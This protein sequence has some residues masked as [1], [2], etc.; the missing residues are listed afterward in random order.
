VLTVPAG[1]LAVR[2]VPVL[3]PGGGKTFSVVGG[4]GLPIPDV[5]SYLGYLRATGHS[6]NTVRAYA[7]HLAFLFRWAAM[8]GVAWE[9]LDFEA[10]VAFIDDMADGTVPALTRAGQARPRQR[11]GRATLE[12]VLAAVCAFLDYWRLEGRG[13]ADLKLYRESRAGGQTS[14]TFLAHVEN[15]N[16]RL[17]RRIKVKGPTS[18]P[19]RTINFEE[20]FAKLIDAASTDRDRTLI[21]AMYD[22]GL[23][24][25]QAL[26]LRHEDLDIARKRLTVIRREDNLNGMLSKQRATFTIDMPGRFFA[27]YGQSLVEEQLALGIDSDY[28]FVSLEPRF[29]G[30]PMTYDNAVRRIKSIGR[31]AGIE[32][33]PHTLRHT[34]GTDLA[35]HDW[36]AP[37][38][39]RR[40][41]QSSAT[42]ADVY[43]HLADEDIAGKYRQT[44]GHL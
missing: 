12:A 35:R 10:F 7:G 11:R 1:A 33:T 38:I 39:A 18:P 44:M 40:L 42:S 17:E 21:S 15:R 4:D 6:A 13:P 28:V 14:R 29:R 3:L 26:G 9:L 16:R 32:L 25:G 37:L 5:E 8:R 20:D 41:G 43:I 30:R 23:R 22:G 27:F 19:P 2:R 36:T 31:R 34:H 24:I